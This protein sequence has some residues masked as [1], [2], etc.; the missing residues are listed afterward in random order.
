MRSISRATHARRVV[1]SLHGGIATLLAFSAA[2]ALPMGCA[3]SGSNLGE[4]A[5]P[6]AAAAVP[7]ERSD[8]LPTLPDDLTIDLTV[9]PGADYRDATQ[10]AFAKS[11]IVQSKYIL[12]P[13]GSLHGDRG[14]TMSVL[15]RPARIRTLSRETV[16]DLWG[17][18]DSAGFTALEETGFRGNPAL[19]APGP[20]EV[21]TVLSVRA[22]GVQG[23][24]IRRGAID[25][26]DPAM[27]R[28]VRAIARLAWT[29]DDPP[30]EAFVQPIRYDLGDDPYARYRP[31][32]PA[33]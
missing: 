7:G 26:L 19:L 2:I 15:T 21:L 30:I 31:A 25:A 28:V 24:F 14:R 9:L 4:P 8:A 22:E 17:L 3:S 11:H 1:R 27:T 5:E 18:L 6:A 12:F 10:P 23:T 13:D 32:A 20:S 33:R 29:T 16:A